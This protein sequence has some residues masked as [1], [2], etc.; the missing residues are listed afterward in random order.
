M[1]PT[2]T[3]DDD[4]DALQATANIL[5]AGV[6]HN[7]AVADAIEVAVK[8]CDLETIRN[9]RRVPGSDDQDP[10]GP[11][12]ANAHATTT[13]VRIMNGRPGYE[14]AAYYY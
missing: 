13:Q 11:P 8:S 1:P 2:T 3:D 14:I 9:V 12:A 4:N 7:K 5:V 10:R 6:A